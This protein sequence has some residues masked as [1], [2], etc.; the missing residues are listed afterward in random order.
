MF[1][2]AIY[3][4]IRPWLIHDCWAAL[5]MSNVL[6]DQQS[7]SCFIFSLVIFRDDALAPCTQ[8]LTRP[9][10]YYH[11]QCCIAISGICQHAFHFQGNTLPS[12][13]LGRYPC[14][15]HFSSITEFTP[16]QSFVSGY[17]GAIQ[18]DCR[19][20]KGCMSAA[21]HRV[22]EIDLYSREMSNL[23]RWDTQAASQTPGRLGSGICYHGIWYCR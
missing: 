4:N 14:L 21:W 18:R 22:C 20:S 3:V 2:F 1:Y 9:H 17:K 7:V 23:L 5:L 11:L 12:V 8:D 10:A 16:V 6:S 19:S 15:R 13:V